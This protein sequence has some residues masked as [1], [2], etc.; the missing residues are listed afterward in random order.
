MSSGLQ[1]VTPS[2]C[3]SNQI[4]V[5]PWPLLIYDNIQPEDSDLGA[6]INLEPSLLFQFS[7]SLH[8]S[9]SISSY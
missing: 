6:Y 5:S 4:D 8:L 9:V 2:G 1:S 3:A 7:E